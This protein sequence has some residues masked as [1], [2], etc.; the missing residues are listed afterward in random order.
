MD[1]ND[2]FDRAFENAMRQG[3]ALD[4]DILRLCIDTILD[5]GGFL[6]DQCEEIMA[7]I[8]E[9]PELLPTSA[10]EAPAWRQKWADFFA[11]RAQWAGETQNGAAENAPPPPMLYE[12]GL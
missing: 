8:K 6:P 11:A 5:S 7:Y 2:V 10:P 1:R 9:K 12:Y 3:Y 4:R